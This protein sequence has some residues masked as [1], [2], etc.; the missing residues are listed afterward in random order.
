MPCPFKAL[1]SPVFLLFKR[2]YVLNRCLNILMIQLYVFKEQN[3][4][5]AFHLIKLNKPLLA[6]I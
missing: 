4:F 6:F 3:V 2:N 5:K 1:L